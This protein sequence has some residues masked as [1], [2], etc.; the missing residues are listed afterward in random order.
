MLVRNDDTIDIV[1]DEVRKGT[2]KRMFLSGIVSFIILFML[3]M[4]MKVDLRIIET[5]IF[6]FGVWCI[7]SYLFIISG[8]IY[9]NQ[10]KE[11]GKLIVSVSKNYVKFFAKKETKNILLKDIIKIN[12]VSSRYG[13]FL[14]I[15]YKEEEKK[16]KYQF[17]FSRSDLNLVCIAIKEFN[18]D[19][20]INEMGEKNNWLI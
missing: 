17:E 10:E 16:Q 3:V 2:S 8:I 13:N 5:Y 20:I 1:K 12:K 14:V 18:Q 4:L 11:N 6:I 7:P 19:I 9:K 15:Y